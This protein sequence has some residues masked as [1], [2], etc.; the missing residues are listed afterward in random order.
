MPVATSTRRG[1]LLLGV[2]LGAV[3]LGSLMAA[4]GVSASDDQQLGDVQAGRETFANQ[5]ARCHGP[6]AA[7]TTV[8]PSL[9]DV[10]ERH[11]VEEIQ[12]TIRQGRGGMPAFGPILDDQEI[13]DVTA[14]LAQVEGTEPVGPRHG[15]GMHRWWDDMMWDGT[16][17]WGFMI[18]WMLFGLLLIVL[19]VVGIVWLVRS[20]GSD[21]GRPSPPPSAPWTDAARGSAREELDR[22][23]A[24]GE[25]DREEYLRVR[26]DLERRS[27]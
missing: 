18:A 17:G 27:D 5:C 22:R 7:G 2:A 26:D 1:M 9:V 14:F 12:D 25:I 16:A 24:R 21:G 4:P 15:P 3:L 13:D 20:V 6:S 19:V 11:T 10:F 8:A 23:Y